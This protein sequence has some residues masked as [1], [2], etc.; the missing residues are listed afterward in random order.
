[1]TKIRISVY[2]IIINNNLNLTIGNIKNVF[3]SNYYILG[4]CKQSHSEY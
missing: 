2:H 1:M 4:V 3:S